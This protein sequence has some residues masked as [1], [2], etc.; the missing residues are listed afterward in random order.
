MA[1]QVPKFGPRKPPEETPAPDPVK[2][3]Q[4]IADA[5]RPA[6]QSPKRL[7][8]QETSAPIAPDAD[9]AR[10]GVVR[11]VHKGDLRRLTVYLPMNVATALEDWCHKN[12]R[13]DL[14]AGVT[15]ALEQ[16]L[17]IK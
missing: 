4:F 11:R 13:Q 9:S 7:V 14:S 5:G 8:T 2:S 16:F 3:A 1:K 15:R 6:N 12:G 17:S 10:P